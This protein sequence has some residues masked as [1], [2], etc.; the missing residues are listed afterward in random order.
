MAWI[1]IVMCLPHRREESARD[2]PGL[3]PDLVRGEAER[4]ARRVLVDAFHLEQ[5]AGGLYSAAPAFRSALAFA[6]GVFRRLLRDR[7]VGEDA[8]PELPA[9]LHVA[10]DRDAARFDLAG[11]EPARLE[12]LQP[13]LPERE[14]RALVRG[15]AHAAALLLPILDLR[16]H[17]HGLGHL[18]PGFRAVEVALVDPALDADLSVRR[19]R[20]REA[21][22]DVGLERVEREATLLIP[23]RPRDL[24]A[25]QAAAAAD[26]DSL[27][28]EAEGR[29][30]ALL[31]RAA[32]RDAA[33]ELHRDRLG[34]ELRVGL[35]ALDLGVVGGGSRAE[36]LLQPVAQLVH[37]RALL[38]DDDAGTGSHDVDLQLVPALDLHFGDRRV[39]EIPLELVAELQVVVQELEVV[40][41]GIPAR[42][43]GAVVADAKTVGGDFLTHRV[44]PLPGRFR[45][46]RFLRLLFV[47]LVFFALVRHVTRL[48][49][50]DPL[51]PLLVGRHLLVRTLDRPILAAGAMRRGGDGGRDATLALLHERLQ[52]LGLEAGFLPRGGSIRQDDRHVAERAR[53]EPHAALRAAHEARAREALLVVRDRAD[54]RIAL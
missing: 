38:P 45:L 30:H 4:L 28:A 8:D 32:K 17:Q 7:L 5:N 42:M 43:P 21:V 27:R 26:L 47:L 36:P 10:L 40:L 12:R 52:S 24:G 16:R 11:G 3:D 34:N 54:H 15:S 29:L 51:G 49:G 35:G 18:P 1:F 33:L 50:F 22:V 13:V 39:R 14:L 20:F 19:A 2:E 31:H 41:L 9:A 23:L 37:G 25:I 46:R 44:L 48:C 6:L 53:D